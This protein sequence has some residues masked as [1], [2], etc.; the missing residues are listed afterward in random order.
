MSRRVWK[1]VENKVGKV[2]MAEAERRREGEESRK[3]TRRGGEEEGI[4]SKETKKG[5]KD[6]SQK[7][8]RKIGDPGW[9]GRSDKVG[10]RGQ[11]TSLR[12]IP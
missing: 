7:N 4:K 6:G 9:R 12:K 8:N 10:G 1:V 3:E 5:E 11:E 2:R